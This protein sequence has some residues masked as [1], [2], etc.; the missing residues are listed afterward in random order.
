MIAVGSLNVNSIHTI[1]KDYFNKG[2][3]AGYFNLGSSM[4]LC[5]PEQNIKNLRVLIDERD[6]VD[7]GEGIIK[8]KVSK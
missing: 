8:I 1:K 4:L 2:D 7:I 5:F 6:K 3:I